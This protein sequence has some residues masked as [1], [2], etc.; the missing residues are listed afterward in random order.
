MSSDP[1]DE[2]RRRQDDALGLSARAPITDARSAER[3]LSRVG[4]ALRYGPTRGLPMA[5]LYRV[6]AGE[7][8]GKA[9]LTAAIA[10]T[11]R[12]LGEAR[13]V[14]VHVIADRV[15]VVHRSVMPAL[16]ALVRR[17]R[18]L[19]DLE[20]LGAHARIALSLLRDQKEIT[21][22][23][24]R[25][26]LGLRSDPRQDPAYAALAEL[27]RLLL[28]DRGP[29]QVAKTGIPYLSSEGY[30]Y[31]LLHEAHA[32]LV[33]EAARRPA[34]TAAE[35]FLAAYL[36][37]AVFAGVRKLATLFKAFLSPAEIAAALK[38]LAKKGSVEVRKI[39]RDTVAVSTTRAKL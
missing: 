9:A 33:K 39:G 17:G 2:L 25:Q 1:L 4:I 23:D 32:D 30:P 7:E 11:N 16:Y 24:V 27:T 29:F 3:F 26:K 38:R 20:G 12:L 14:E 15:T 35:E 18:A 22:G 8:P 19:D 13:G 34:T 5:S 28:V 6:F 10:L 21:A 31:H 37:G 36:G